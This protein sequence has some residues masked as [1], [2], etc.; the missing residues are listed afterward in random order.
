MYS[1]VQ[2]HNKSWI[3]AIRERFHAVFTEATKPNSILGASYNFFIHIHVITRETEAE[4]LKHGSQ[5]SFL[6]SG[7]APWVCSL[8]SCTQPH[9]WRAL[10][11]CWCLEIPINCF[12]T[13]SPTI[14][15]YPGPCKL[16]SQ[17]CLRC[18]LN[19]G[20]WGTSPG[21]FSG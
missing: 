2:I 11:C 16:C 20:S 19:S 1:N 9:A 4:F 12:L 14:S 8:Y 6:R 18:V 3:N 21:W 7:P 15:F 5:S 13:K 10:L 17:S